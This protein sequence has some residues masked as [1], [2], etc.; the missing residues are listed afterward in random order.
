[1][2]TSKIYIR[3]ILLSSA[4]Y[5]NL[6]VQQLLRREKNLGSQFRYPQIK[7]P[8]QSSST[9]HPPSPTLHGAFLLQHSI[10]NV[11]PPVH[12]NLGCSDH[13]KIDA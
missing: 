5:H 10:S 1:M 13:I 2:D 8:S 9:L 11:A 6:P 3:S 7:S 12:L 4:Y